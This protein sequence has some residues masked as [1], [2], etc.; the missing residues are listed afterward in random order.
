M[1]K[2]TCF[3]IQPDG[4]VKEYDSF[5]TPS[6]RM[7]GRHNVIF[8]GRMTDDKTVV[9]G[10]STK[11]AVV[12]GAISPQYYL[13]ILQLN[14]IPTDQ[15]MPTYTVSADLAGS[16]KFHKIGAA[17]N[18][19][20]I[21][22]ASWAYG[23]MQVTGAG[24]TTFPHYTDSSSSLSTMDAFT[25]SYYPDTGSEGHTWSTFANFVTLAI[26]APAGNPTFP[27]SPSGSRRYLLFR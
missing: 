19:A 26:M 7:D 5:A 11:K 24:V 15:A 8:T 27:L 6:S 3:G 10:V 22:Q 2:V 13:R 25:F 16:Y 1:W 18:S 23:K 9:V 14:F 21:S 4:L 17:L 20:G 12:T